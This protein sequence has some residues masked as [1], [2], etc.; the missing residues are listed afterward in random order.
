MNATESM[1]TTMMKLGPLFALVLLI[2]PR[3]AL[4]QKPDP[5][6]NYDES[7]VRAY[8]LP[9]PLTTARGAKITDAAAW[10]QERRPE[11]LKL[12]ETYVYGK[13]PGKLPAMRFQ[14]TSEKK[15]ACGGKATRKEVSIL[16]TGQPDGPKMDLLLYIPN[17]AQKPVPAFLGLNFA[18]NQSVTKEP[19]VA[20]SAQWMRDDPPRGI[21]DHRATAKTRGS[22]A[23]SW[24]IERVIDRGYALATAYYGDLD[25][26]YDDGFRNG[27]HPL[28]A[29]PGSTGRAPDDWGAIGAWAWGLSRA[30]DYLETEPVIDAQKVVVMGHSRLGKTALWAG[31]TDPRF[32]IVVSIQSGCGG[33]ALS[34]R[35][36]GETVKRINTSFPHWFALNF[37]QFNDHEDDLPVDQHELIALI[38][39]RPVLITSAEEDRWAD[40]KG[41]FLGAKGAD[42]VYRLL[43]T[44]GLAVAAMPKPNQLVKSTIGY[45]LR[46]GE[47]RVTDAEWQAMLDFADHHFHRE[48][49]TP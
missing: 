21:V 14:V 37:R 38:A 11:L 23:S 6:I 7:K 24:A 16:F 2:L 22:D 3:P 18:G 40:P 41:E 8:T 42:P 29:K 46:P 45:F 31:A 26:D 48:S 27:V 28:F 15:T 13:M 20:I 12:F 34:R 17:Q 36:Y 35:W 19:D 49:A 9:D 10:N 47:H 33:A 32:A 43:G 4:A 25:P 1:R 44:D 39:P 5:D 30:L